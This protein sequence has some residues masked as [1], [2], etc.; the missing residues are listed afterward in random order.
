VPG[1]AL[2]PLA[3]VLPATIGP[4]VTL[5]LIGF[6]VGV[7]GHLTRSRWLVMAGI[8]LVFGAAFLFPLARIVGEGS[9]PPPP[10]P[11]LQ[12]VP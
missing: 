5:M 2:V 7:A 10:D 9:P 8:L 3:D 12:H 11:R 4:Y 6:F 1:A